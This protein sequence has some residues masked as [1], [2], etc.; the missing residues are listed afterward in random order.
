MMIQKEK[1]Q[2]CKKECQP[3]FNQF[4]C[5]NGLR[6][7]KKGVWGV[8]EAKGKGEEGRWK[9]ERKE[10]NKGRRKHNIKQKDQLNN[11]VTELKKKTKKKEQNQN[12]MIA[13]TISK[14]E[15]IS[16]NDIVK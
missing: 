7:Q 5:S 14:L 8:R 1:L 12:E 2:S 10:R 4:L 9:K 15:N 11:S 16:Q 3:T 6:L 13:G